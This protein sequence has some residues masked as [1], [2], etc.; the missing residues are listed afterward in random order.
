MGDIVPFRKPVSVPV[1]RT[2]WRV[3]S[4]SRGKA[5]PARNHH[6][7]GQEVRN[8]NHDCAMSPAIFGWVADW[9]TESRTV[10]EWE[11]Q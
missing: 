10:S 4:P 11:T 2:E 5:Y 9:R 1:S 7:A 8:N 3:Y 6:E